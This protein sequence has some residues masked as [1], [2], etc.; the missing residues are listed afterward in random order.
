MGRTDFHAKS[1]PS[2]AVAQAG[3]PGSGDEVRI[4]GVALEGTALTSKTFANP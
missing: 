3:R 1:S 2:R 4:D